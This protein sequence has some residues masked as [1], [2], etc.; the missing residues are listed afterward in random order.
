MAAQRCGSNGKGENAPENED[1]QV[2]I[3]QST[4]TVAFKAPP[5]CRSAEGSR[6]A[7]EPE[8]EPGEGEEGREGN[9]ER[10]FS[11]LSAIGNEDV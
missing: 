7:L 6:P 11:L 5:A 1:A 2:V 4:C 8:V 10:L 3:K 9:D